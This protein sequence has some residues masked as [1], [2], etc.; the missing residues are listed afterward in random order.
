MKLGDTKE[1]ARYDEPFV[2]SNRYRD[3]YYEA[4]RVLLKQK[5]KNLG[6]LSQKETR[7]RPESHP[8][9]PP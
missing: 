7:L 5:F 4:S 1:E 8:G 2:K 3:H 6:K 9:S